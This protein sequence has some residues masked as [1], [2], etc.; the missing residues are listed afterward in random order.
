LCLSFSVASLIFRLYAFA[1][2][3]GEGKSARVLVHGL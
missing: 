3:M 2:L 1:A